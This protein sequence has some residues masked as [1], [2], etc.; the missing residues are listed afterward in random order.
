MELIG[1]KPLSKVELTG[2]GAET[3]HS[4]FQVLLL[5]RHM[6]IN[7]HVHQSTSK[8]LN[9]ITP[10]QDNKCYVTTSH[11]FCTRNSAKYNSSKKSFQCPWEFL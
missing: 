2:V 9:N 1:V 6:V 8:P 7:N 3:E 11:S 5:F 10:I 4:L